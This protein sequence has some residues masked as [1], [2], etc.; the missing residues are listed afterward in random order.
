MK[1]ENDAEWGVWKDIFYIHYYPI[2]K[3]P[4]G[5]LIR[6]PIFTKTFEQ[7]FDQ[8]WETAKP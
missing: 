5:F 3:K 1:L 4:Y 8:L 2:K 7:T 6:D